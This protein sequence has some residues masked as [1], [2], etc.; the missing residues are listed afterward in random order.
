MSKVVTRF[1]PSP[2]GLM[3]VGGLRTAL[4][5]YLFAKSQKGKFNLRIDDTD[6]SRYLETAEDDILNNFKLFGLKHDNHL[7]RQSE[8]IDTYQKFALELVE[9]NKAYHCF[10]STERL[11]KMRDEQRQRKQAPLYDR[12]CYKLPKEEVNKRLSQKESNVIRMYIPEAETIEFNDLIRGQVSFRTKEIDDQVLLKSDGFPTYH[13][14]NVID[15]Y[16]MGVTHVLRGEEWLSSTPKHILLYEYFGWRPPIFAHLPLLL[17]PDKSKLSK[18]VG[19]VAVTNYLER[20]YVPDALLNFVLLLGWNPG[21]DQ[22][23]FSLKEMIK[24]FDISKIH[25]AGAVFDLAKLDWMNGQYLRSMPF[26]KFKDLTEEIINQ[27]YPS[28]KLDHNQVEAVLKLEQDRIEKLAE[29]GDDVGFFFTDDLVYKKS[30]LNWKKNKPSQTKEYLTELLNFIK[31]LPAAKFKADKLEMA[32]KEFISNHSFGTGDVLWPMRVA[33]T[34]LDKSPGPFEVAAILG[35]K[36]T[37]YRI[38]KAINM[39]WPTPR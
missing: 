8:N 12:L 13:L 29:V 39:L 7:F 20:G 17:N 22:E 24:I 11:A 28:H 33:L 37:L 32:I 4:Y 18:R 3:H 30:L 15:D 2:T 31:A 26:K 27:K 6:R 10:C 34:G 38:E 23:I 36:K 35:R 25:K 5:N 1:A 14:A 21:T 9:N 16:K 19:D